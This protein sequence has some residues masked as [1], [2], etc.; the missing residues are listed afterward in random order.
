MNDMSKVIVPRSDQLNSDDLIAGPRT[1]TIT[2][3]SI[4]PGTEQPVSLHFE[5]DEGKPWKACK[6]MARILV[7]AWGA[8]ANNYAGRSLTLYRDPTVKWAGMEVGGIRVSHMSHI[9]GPMTMA[10]TATK[11]SRK[12]YTVKPL[13]DAPAT[14]SAKPT[15][16]EA[17]E[18]FANGVM[19]ELAQIEADRDVDAFDAFTAKKEAAILKKLANYPALAETIT[20]RITEIRAAIG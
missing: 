5:G 12:P 1:V 20:T 10:L 3:V 11:G 7:A 13:A 2:G 9:E 6:S 4:R 17:A 15:A 18:T 8:D 14:T 16:A 19:A